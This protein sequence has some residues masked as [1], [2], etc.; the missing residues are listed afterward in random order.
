MAGVGFISNQT[1]GKGA[2]AALTGLLGLYMTA[3]MW[4]EFNEALGVFFGPSLG[5]IVGTLI[6]LIYQDRKNVKTFSSGKNYSKSERTTLVKGAD[7]RY[8]QVESNIEKGR[9]PVLFVAMLYFA[10]ILISEISWSDL[11]I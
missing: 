8:T 11:I 6:F 3:A 1:A 9:N 5:V 2:I 7:G 4:V 10:I